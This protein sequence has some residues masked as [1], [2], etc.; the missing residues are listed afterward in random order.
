MSRETQKFLG[1]P[2]GFVLVDA[3]LGLLF[4]LAYT[5]VPSR[6]AAWQRSG[7]LALGG[8]LAL[9]VKRSRSGTRVARG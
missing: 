6:A 3:S 5:L 1:M 4:A 9:A 2:N 8:F 7:G